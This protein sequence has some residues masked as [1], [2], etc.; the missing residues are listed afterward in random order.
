MRLVRFIS[1]GVAVGMVL[2]GSAW[3]QGRPNPSPL[4]GYLIGGAGMAVDPQTT[5]TLL[6]EI[7]E[8]VNRDVQFYF[9][10][11]YYDNLMSQDTQDQLDAIARNLTFATGAPWQFSGR[12]RGRSFT[13]GAKYLARTGS[14]VRPY[15][16]GGIGVINLRR[17]IN[18]STRGNLTNEFAAEF[19]GVDDVLDT[20]QTNTNRPLGEIAGGVGVVVR[21]AY[22]DFGYRWRSAFHTHSQS[23]N[24]GSFGVAAGV[25]F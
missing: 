9:G 2:S 18:E 16:G 23:L 17:T 7:A 1:V 21:K 6:F 11:G 20:S 25:K 5:P 12:D 15:I 19:G 8:N 3:A 14:P 4:R 24:F 22:I 10:V 13:V